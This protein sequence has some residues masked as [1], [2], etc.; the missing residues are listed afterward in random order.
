MSVV[1]F[2]HWPWLIP[3]K[4][5]EPA[6]CVCM[7]CFIWASFTH[8]L[9]SAAS[10]L[11]EIEIWCSSYLNPW[12]GAF[13]MGPAGPW[14]GWP[15]LLSQSHLLT[16][17][18]CSLIWPHW[19]YFSSSTARFLPAQPLPMGFP[20]AQTTSATPHTWLALSSFSLSLIVTSSRTPFWPSWQI[21]P[22]QALSVICA[23][24]STDYSLSGHL[25]E[26]FSNACLFP[27]LYH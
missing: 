2:L 7:D 5:A 19:S 10:D 6:V 25:Y 16:L 15:H 14:V 8:A 12:W 3:V 9:F 18:P 4:S 26:F 27:Q 11:S 13:F 17:L 21:P 24:Y 23:S 1:C 20:S 22:P